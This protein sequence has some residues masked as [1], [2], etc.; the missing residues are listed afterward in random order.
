MLMK[1]S[2]RLIYRWRFSKKGLVPVILNL[3]V[4]VRSKGTP[5]NVGR[6]VDGRIEPALVVNHQIPTYKV[7]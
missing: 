1:H 3:M 6:F 4:G 7:A 5:S 2:P